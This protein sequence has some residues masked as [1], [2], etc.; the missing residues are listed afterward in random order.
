MAIIFLFYQK[1]GKICKED[2][3]RLENQVKIILEDIRKNKD[4]LNDNENNSYFISVGSE[5]DQDII[6]K[7][8]LIGTNTLKYNR[9]RLKFNN[10]SYRFGSFYF[11]MLL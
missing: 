1:W 10:Y 4:K 5:E 9:N 7:N 3:Y 8:E 2:N 6:I 11:F